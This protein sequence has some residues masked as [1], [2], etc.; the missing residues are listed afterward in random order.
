MTIHRLFEVLK[1]PKAG[2]GASSEYLFV[3]S[4]IVAVL[5]LLQVHP[6]WYVALQRSQ[7][8]VIMANQ[9]KVIRRF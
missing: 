6:V 2:S 4:A 5:E 1:L 7:D 3:F 8:A 9:G